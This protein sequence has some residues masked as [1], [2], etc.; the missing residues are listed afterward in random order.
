MP[1]EWIDDGIV[2]SARKHGESSAIVTLLTRQHGRHAGLVRGGTGKRLRGILQPGNSVQASWRGRLAEHLGTYTIDAGHAYAAAAL[3]DPLRLA[4]LT[5]AAALAET[6]LPEREPHPAIY[7]GLEVLLAN[8]EHDDVWPIIYIK[9]ELGLLSELGFGLDLNACAATGSIDDLT[10]VSP[11]SGRAVSTDAAQP[12]KD[13]LL[14]LPTFLTT[15]GLGG[16]SQEIRQGLKLTGHFLE[17][18]VFA[19]RDANLP[20]ARR[21]LADRFRSE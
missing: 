6:A 1:M 18:H 16:N 7:E 9:W 3:S 10:Y 19:H 4:A 15:S 8:L 20:A 5:S 11:K 14:P 12:Y 13:R 17:H 21:R 2:L